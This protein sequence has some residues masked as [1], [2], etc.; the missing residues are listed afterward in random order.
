MLYTNTPD[1]TYNLGVLLL[2]A[3]R[4]GE[5]IEI[6]QN[7]KKWLSGKDIKHYSA[8]ERFLHE[9]VS[10]SLIKAYTEEGN[11]LQAKIEERELQNILRQNNLG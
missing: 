3:G 5:S 2:D 10:G 1:D 7:L 8:Y 4:F 9:D 6:F 11:I